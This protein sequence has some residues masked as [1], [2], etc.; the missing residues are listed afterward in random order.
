MTGG[1]PN[2]NSLPILHECG[3]LY[4]FDARAHSVESGQPLEQLISEERFGC[5]L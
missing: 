1:Y 2:S 3:N 5:V 4:E